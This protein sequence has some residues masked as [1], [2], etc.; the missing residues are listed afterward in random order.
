M[1]TRTQSEFVREVMGKLGALGAGQ[2]PS[3]EDDQLVKARLSD[4]IEQLEDDDL[5]TFD[6]ADGIPGKSFIPLAYLVAVHL[7]DHFGAQSQAQ[8]IFTGAQW[9]EKQ[10]RR[11]RQD[12]KYESSR[13]TPD[14]F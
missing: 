4:V 9:G 11:Q 2:T 12:G 14:Y 7:I 5:I 13:A 1:T 8:T 6:I 10:L 3:A